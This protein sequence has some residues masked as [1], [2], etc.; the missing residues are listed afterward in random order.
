[1]AMNAEHRSRFA[2]LHRQWWRLHMSEFSN[3]INKQMQIN[4]HISMDICIILTFKKDDVFL[5]FEIA[6]TKSSNFKTIPCSFR[7]IIL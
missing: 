6:D 7:Y 1:M 3:K 5:A 2:S 4:K